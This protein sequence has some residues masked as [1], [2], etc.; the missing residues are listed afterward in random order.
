MGCCGGGTATIDVGEMVSV[1]LK[2]GQ[3]ALTIL[4]IGGRI[5]RIPPD[6]AVVIPSVNAKQYSAH[7]DVAESDSA[8]TI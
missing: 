3:G 7:L 1:V 4:T 8:T 6:T 2:P 5:V